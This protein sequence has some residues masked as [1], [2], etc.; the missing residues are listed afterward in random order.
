MTTLTPAIIQQAQAALSREDKTMAKI[1]KGNTPLKI[2]SQHTPFEHLAI[3][4]INQQ[5]SQKAADTIEKRVR[6]LTPLQSDSVLQTAD[7]KLRQSGL[8]WRKVEYL[9][10]LAQADLDGQLQV[11]KLK[12]L[13]DEAVIKHL[14]QLKGIGR[15][16]AEMFL[17]FALRRPD[18]VALDDAGLQRAVVKH[19]RN[20]NGKN[21]VDLL[22]H[23]S[24]KWKPWRTVACWHLWRS[25]D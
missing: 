22:A 23:R 3:S 24:Q 1:I 19:Y 7:D 20:P 14:C 15:W 13:D 18:I 4:I 17:M 2:K 11:K 25:L 16:T 10:V 9:K 8:S 21:S 5:L 12:Q 6:Q